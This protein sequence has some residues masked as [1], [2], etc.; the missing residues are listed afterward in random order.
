MVRVR[1]DVRVALSVT[2]RVDVGVVGVRVVQVALL[3]LGVGR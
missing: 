2:M 3:L 1:R